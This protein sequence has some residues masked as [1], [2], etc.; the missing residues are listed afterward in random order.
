MNSHNRIKDDQFLNITDE[1]EV[2]ILSKSTQSYRLTLYTFISWM[3]RMDL[4]T[5]AKCDF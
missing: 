5:D 2:F 3:I 4:L 1:L